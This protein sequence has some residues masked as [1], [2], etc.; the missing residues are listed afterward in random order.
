VNGREFYSFEID[1]SAEIGDLQKGFYLLQLKAE[2]G[3]VVKKLAI[4]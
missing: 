4:H 3:L 2:R 1:G